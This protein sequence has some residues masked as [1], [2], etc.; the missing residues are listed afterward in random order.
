MKKKLYMKRFTLCDAILFW[1]CVA[2]SA[3]S[4]FMFLLTIEFFYSILSLAMMLVSYW[5]YKVA[6]LINREP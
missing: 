6:L 5:F 2:Q 3:A 1:I 4:W